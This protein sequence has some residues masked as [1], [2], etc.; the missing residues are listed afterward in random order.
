MAWESRRGRRYL[1]HTRRVDGRFVRE[2]YG[3]G[4]GAEYAQRL[5]TEPRVKRAAEAEATGLEKARLGPLDGLIEELDA[6]CRL[7]VD[8]TLLGAG[9]WRPFYAWRRRNDREWTRQLGL[10]ASERSAR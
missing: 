7:L 3:T 5:I 8:A 1:Y 2:Y 4:A 9:Y 10:G 6:V